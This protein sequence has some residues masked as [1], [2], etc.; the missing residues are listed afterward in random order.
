MKSTI[1]T[2]FFFWSTLL[3][4]QA[5]VV[6]VAF[7]FQ[8]ISNHL[9]VSR[10]RTSRATKSVSSSSK[11]EQQNIP[12]HGFLC[13]PLQMSGRGTS[14]YYSWTEEAFELEVT[15]QVPKLTRAKDILFKAN[16][17]SIQLLLC[18]DNGARIILLDPARK[19]RGKVVVDG[20]YWMISDPERT[21]NKDKDDDDDVDEDDDRKD[22][23]LVTVTIEKRIRKPK[24][25]FDVIDYDWKGVYSE[26]EA[27]VTFR[28]YDQAEKLDIRD[29]AASLGVDIDNINM[30]MV[31]K[32]RGIERS[33]WTYAGLGFTERKLKDSLMIVFKMLLLFMNAASATR[34]PCFHP[35]STLRKV[36][37]KN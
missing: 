24:D 1:L 12:C 36:R 31:D 5:G 16:S 20:T 37:W 9:P 8:S 13:P 25:D 10:T 3:C 11:Q 23:R 17:T 32:V 19:L 30:S 2:L 4:P 27:E 7:S 18:Y 6:V 26:D 28:E 15:V 34:R 14:R 33:V 21:T 22:D 29:Y 35:G